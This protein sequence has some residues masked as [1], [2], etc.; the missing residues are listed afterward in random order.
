MSHT[1]QPAFPKIRPCSRRIRFINPHQIQRACF[2]MARLSCQRGRQRQQSSLSDNTTITTTALLLI[3]NYSPLIRITI[4]CAI[5]NICLVSVQLYCIPKSV[6]KG[7]SLCKKN[8]LL[9]TQVERM[10]WERT[11]EKARGLWFIMG[12]GSKTAE[13]SMLCN[14]S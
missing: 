9:D 13:S 2:F 7:T 4:H 12:N 11:S 10:K 3:H 6:T 5:I 14:H 8:T 1:C